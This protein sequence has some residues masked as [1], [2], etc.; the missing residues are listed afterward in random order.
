MRKLIMQG[1]LGV[2]LVSLCV[3][4]TQARSTGRS[5]AALPRDSFLEYR[6]DTVEALARQAETNPRVRARYARQFGIPAS[7]VAQYIRQNLVVSYLPKSGTYR[8]YYVTPGG[9]IYSRQR[10][11]PR[12]TRVLT[13]RN[14]EPVMRWICGNAMVP[15]L[16]RVS[17]IVQRPV[18]PV[19]VVMSTP[20][21]TVPM[22]TRAISVPS[23]VTQVTVLPFV[24]APP[25]AIAPVPA[26]VPVAAA[27]V[28]VPTAPIPIPAAI[29]PIAAG[30]II[31]I[32]PPVT[33]VPVPTEVPPPE[34]PIPEANSLAM[35]VF[36]ALPVM[37]GALRSRCA[38]TQT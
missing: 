34:I 27:P 9:R 13:L 19:P 28:P 21:E 38:R 15:S 11:L 23:E 35:L 24:G 7:R 33:P 22:V 17:P 2:A 26:P 29:I 37:W 32:G 12:G 25:P 16:P 5:S 30:G 1:L 3:T 8:V 31:P 10:N 20:A 6:A 14:G 36:A 4:A 18:V